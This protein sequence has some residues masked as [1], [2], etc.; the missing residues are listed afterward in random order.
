[1]VTSIMILAL[2][3]G[4]AIGSFLP[5]TNMS[6]VHPF[7]ED[8]EIAARKEQLNTSSQVWAI[9]F[10]VIIILCAAPHYKESSVADQAY[11]LRESM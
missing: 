5:F 1:M 6:Y 7:T 2:P 3:L 4:F 8:R 10:T 11:F 9:I